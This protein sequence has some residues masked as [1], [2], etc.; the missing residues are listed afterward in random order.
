M[1]DTNTALFQLPLLP[2]FLHPSPS[3]SH[4]QSSTFCFSCLA[5]RKHT[6]F[7]L[8]HI[9]MFASVPLVLLVCSLAAFVPTS[10][11]QGS[12]DVA[13]VVIAKPHSPPTQMNRYAKH[14]PHR[15]AAAKKCNATQIPSDVETLASKGSSGYKISEQWSGS[16]FFEGW[17]FFTRP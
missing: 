10:I 9:N 5:K 17:N 3:L 12:E 6:R 7:I 4:P 16:D 15:R 11:A 2:S 8:L 1:R 14:R 13:N